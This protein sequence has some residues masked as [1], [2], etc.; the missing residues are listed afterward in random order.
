MLDSKSPMQT[1]DFLDSATTHVAQPTFHGRTG[2]RLR[3]D[4]SYCYQLTTS[5]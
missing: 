1:I 4:L 3:L 2:L 5:H